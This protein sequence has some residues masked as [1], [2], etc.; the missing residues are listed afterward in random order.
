MYLN[1]VCVCIHQAVS[2]TPVS[3]VSSWMG[4]S[5]Y[6]RVIKV[7]ILGD[8]GRQTF[9]I[10]SNTIKRVVC[11][12]V[13]PP[14]CMYQIYGKY[15]K[16]VIKYVAVQLYWIGVFVRF[17]V[18]R[19]MHSVTP[20]QDAVHIVSRQLRILYTYCHV[21]TKCC[22]HNVTSVQ[23]AVHK[24]LYTLCHANKE[25]CTQLSGYVQGPPGWQL[26]Q[27][28]LSKNRGID[29]QHSST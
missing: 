14:A 21:S 19:C 11:M 25:C 29:T 2:P 22:T 18:S 17:G 16:W 5:T 4:C 20:I 9:T 6:S 28:T 27:Q 23:N 13:C 10:P 15:I 24:I 12:C 26:S 8:V 3:S 1:H 7:T